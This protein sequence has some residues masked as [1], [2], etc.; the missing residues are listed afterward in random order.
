MRPIRLTMTAFGPFA[1]TEVVDFRDA[2]AAGLF[3]I[4]GPT[5]SG[6]SSIFNA[7]TFAL[8]GES[9]KQGQDVKSL[10]SDHAAASTATE[11]EFIFE[12]GNKRFVL[13][14]SPEQFRPKARGE[15]E[16]RQ[17]HEAYLFDAT[18]IPPDEITATNCG[19][20]IAEKKVR[21]VDAA[22]HDLL[23]YGAAQ[24]RQII[25]LPQGDFEKFL[26]SSSEDRLGILR[27]LF[28][29]S[30]YRAL[31]EWFK[32]AAAE[33]RRFIQEARTKYIGRLEGEGFESR[34]ALAS[35][36]EV[37][38]ATLLEQTEAETAIVV[39]ATAAK[40]ELT[41]A[42][43]LEA[44]F[45]AA[46]NAQAKLSTC[47]ARKLEISEVKTRVF[48]AKQAANLLDVE[49]QAL[50]AGKAS[51]DAERE[52]TEER[53]IATKVA[54]AAKIALEVFAA[55]HSRRGEIDELKQA[56]ADLVRHRETL[57]KAE[58]KKEVLVAVGAT[59]IKSQKILNQ[60]KVHHDR[61]V[62]QLNKAV[63]VLESARKA[64]IE[65]SNLMTEKNKNR[66]EATAANFYETAKNQLSNAESDLIEKTHVEKTALT[67][68]GK[69][70]EVLIGAEAALARFQAIILADKLQEGQPCSVCG[71]TKHPAPASGSREGSDLT[72]T[73]RAA[74]AVEK[75]AQSDWEKASQ[76]LAVAK[77]RHNDRLESFVK[78]VVPARSFETYEDALV[79]IDDKLSALG[80]TTDVA[81]L[82]QTLDDLKPLIESS[83]NSLRIATDDK[84][85]A[86]KKR[87]LADQAL[88]DALTSVPD[89]LREPGALDE[90]AQGN[91][92]EVQRRTKA[93]Q[94]ADESARR[95]K[96]IS[97]KANKD[98]E[99][100]QKTVA[101]AK[102]TH[103]QAQEEFMQRLAQAGMTAETFEDRKTNIAQIEV[104]EIE[105]KKFE[106]DL[107]GA[108]ALK[109]STANAIEGQERPNLEIFI[110]TDKNAK[111]AAQIASKDRGIAVGRVKQLETLANGIADEVARVAELEA[112]TA[113]QQ[114]LAAK[115]NGDNPA[116]LTLEAFAIRS[117]FDQVLDAANLRLHPMSDGRYQLE[118]DDEGGKGRAKQGLGIR[119][120]DVHTGTARSTAS[121]SGGETFIAALALALGL[122][123]V[124][125]SNAGSI[126]LD[127]IFIDEGFGSLDAEDSGT[128]DQVLQT[129]GDTTG[130]SRAV[131]LISH[132]G[133]VKD[134]IPNGFQI[135]KTPRGSHIQSRGVQ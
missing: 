106:S 105:I 45:R 93:L 118:R 12:L 121:L 124:V 11:V 28:D 24:F 39:I 3:G 113:P 44:L 54:E 107:A 114:E 66:T 123:D 98:A 117:M 70:N 29:V 78:L 18:G 35:G 91:K 53:R 14:R 49:D 32:E 20:M 94:D 75:D 55:Q 131:G 76:E 46:E 65:R 127:T 38:K 41:Y 95:E 37:A 7:M 119:V 13:R 1:G 23:G 83:E 31:A 25:L 34:D 8:F 62:D 60:A 40:N 100:A 63:L 104:D 9:A 88:K 128:L 108:T 79:D 115:F 90:A 22:V 4:Y 6:K 71:S 101:N 92:D 84:T 130:H 109:L 81:A 16:T 97:L 42:Q 99:A 64:D 89:M 47:E 56:G 73:W 2:L 57:T 17:L 125:E 87:A 69:A 5:G 129:L 116:H 120:H 26:T 30:Q 132:V 111:D 33:S 102:R 126:R 110:E 135:E 48:G 80:A 122:S 68:R 52:S 58:T 15:G 85:E 77:Q 134:A 96:E 36:I 19:N 133:M 50:R 86:E 27:P 67:A 103:S 112:Q 61:L 10:R 72:D 74:Q 82:E 43:Q 51:I 59:L 21:D